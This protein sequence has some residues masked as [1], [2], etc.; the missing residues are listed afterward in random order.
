MATT[1]LENPILNGP[2]DPPARH[3]ALGPSGP[4]G[5]IKTG[6]RPSESFIPVPATRKGKKAGEQ[7]ALDFEAATT[8]TSD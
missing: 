5:E 1:A 4:T 8:R 6:R 7:V 3:F 2:Y